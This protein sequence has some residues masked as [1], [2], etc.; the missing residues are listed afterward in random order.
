[1]AFGKFLVKLLSLA[2]V[3]VTI[4][5]ASP[6]SNTTNA[7]D[8]RAE[9]RAQVAYFTNWQVKLVYHCFARLFTCYLTGEYTGPISVSHFP[10]VPMLMFAD[11]HDMTDRAHRHQPC[12]YNPHPLLLRG[13]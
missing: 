10:Y 3:L 9:G 8:K 11:I 1:M 7:L 5:N 4:A 13:R 2:S 12:S 6:I